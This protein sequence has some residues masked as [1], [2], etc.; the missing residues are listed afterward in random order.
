[1][2]L[3]AQFAEAYQRGDAT[4]E[5]LAFEIARMAYP[6]LDVEEQ[7]KQL[8]TLAEFV[9]RELPGTSSGAGSAPGGDQGDLAPADFMRVITQ[10]LDF[11]GNRE[12]Y[13]DPRN[14]LLPDVL[15]RRMGL[16][17]MLC[18]VCIALGRRLGVR[19]EGLGFPSHFL[20]VFR[21]AGGDT[22]L[23][24][25]LG[26]T[27]DPTAVERHL[28]QLLGQP[29]NLAP[30]F[31]RALTSQE[32]ALRILRNLRNAYLT[33]KDLAMVERVLD[34]LIA[35]IPSEP[36]YWRERGL[37]HYRQQHWLEAHYDLRGYLQ[38]VGLFA[39]LAQAPTPGAG[40]PQGAPLPPTVNQ[41]DRRVLEI[42]RETSS[43]LGR[44]N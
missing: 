20:A 3:A 34:Y 19:I 10:G 39:S 44:V 30:E 17:I 43:M 18:V 42:Y 21:T 41:G 15:E 38:R 5:R 1:M 24:P 16:P 8:D 9:Q 32:I 22:V 29:V 36:Q 33:A 31:W 27:L 37:L 40:E 7:L 13:Y 28:A 11:H 2:T 26:L 14:S 25:F 23:D 12:D 4:P 6:A 35:A